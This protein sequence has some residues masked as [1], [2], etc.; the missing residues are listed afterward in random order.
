MLSDKTIANIVACLIVVMLTTRITIACATYSM[1]FVVLLLI[2]FFIRT[3]NRNL[4]FYMQGLFLLPKEIYAGIFIFYFSLFIAS[5][6]N[7]DVPG[8]KKTLDF[9]TW[10][11]PLWLI[12]ITAGRY[13]ITTGIKYGIAVGTMY[14]CGNGLFQFYQGYS[15]GNT[16]I[17]IQANFWNAN[18]LAMALEILFP[19]LVVFTMEEQVKIKKIFFFLLSLITFICLYLTQSRGALGGIVLAYIVSGGIYLFEARMMTS[20]TKLRKALGVFCVGILIMGASLGYLAV[21]RYNP[22]DH[23][24]G[25]ERGIMYESSL[26][27]WEDNKLAG[28]G[29]ASWNKAYNGKYQPEYYEDKGHFHPHNM[30]LNYLSTAG[31]IGE[32]GFILYLILLFKGGY[33]CIKQSNNLIN[34]F[35]IFTPLMAYL[36]HGFL[37]DT[38][39]HKE[40]ARLFYL[41]LGI[42]IIYCRQSMK[43]Q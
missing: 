40:I 33:K 15:A 24:F 23:R 1:W 31:I 11:I 20:K 39:V 32:V 3:K 19:L 38:L 43:T 4:S 13:K 42:I 12:L 36:F 14:L 10:T 7:L 28:V 29:V 18:L 5:A 17:R 16:S 8:L 21:Q 6:I 30:F 22:N 2:Y 26:K 41:I 34:L 35:L 37:D 25:A 27:M 9:I